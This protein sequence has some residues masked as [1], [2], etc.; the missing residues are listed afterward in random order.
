MC[1]WCVSVRRVWK[2]VCL[3][4]DDSPASQALTAPGLSRTSHPALPRGSNQTAGGPAGRSPPVVPAPG[5]ELARPS[6]GSARPAPEVPGQVS[7]APRSSTHGVARP[8]P[9]R[10]G[11]AQLSGR[12]LRCSRMVAHTRWIPDLLR[13]E[14]LR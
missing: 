2:R 14:E 1:V 7:G 13:A 10:L 12:R 11:S 6:H 5:R 9:A 3:S 4:G 8:G